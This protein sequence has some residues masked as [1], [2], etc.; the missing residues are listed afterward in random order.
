MAC[1]ISSTSFSVSARMAG[2]YPEIVVTVRIGA[3]HREASAGCKA[4]WA[5]AGRP[6]YSMRMWDQ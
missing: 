1:L 6:I 2:A 5:G 3:E 4:K